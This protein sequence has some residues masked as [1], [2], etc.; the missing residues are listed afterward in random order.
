MHRAAAYSAE[1]KRITPQY[2]SAP[3]SS[4]ET[5][6]YASQPAAPASSE[7]SISDCFVLNYLKLQSSI[8]V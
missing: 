5:G 3:F 6:A 1:N 7:N 4:D 2:M 8:G